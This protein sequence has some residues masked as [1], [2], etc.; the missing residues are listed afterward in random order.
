R[1]ASREGVVE[2]APGVYKDVEDVVEVAQNS[3]I[4]RKVAR[5][6]PMGVMKG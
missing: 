2:E 6:R 5:M 3:G 1:S 4:A